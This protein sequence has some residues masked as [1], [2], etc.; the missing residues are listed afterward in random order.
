MSHSENVVPIVVFTML[1]APL[2]FTLTRRF[3][4]R[5]PA[6][7]AAP[8]IPVFF[9]LTPQQQQQTAGFSLSPGNLSTHPPKSPEKPQAQPKRDLVAELY[10]QVGQSEIEKLVDDFYVGVAKD[11]IIGPLYEKA[12]KERGEPDLGGAQQRLA[13]YLVGRFGGP[14]VYVEKHGHP[15]LKARHFSFP[16]TQEGREHW[17]TIMEGAVKSRKFPA[18]VEA[19]MMEFF[20]GL[21]VHMINTPN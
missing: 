16:V 3:L 7:A 9:P 4:F 14:P 6:L 10:A 20:S 18:P 5:A 13:E 8:V 2:V 21:S 17:M 19:T 11:P 15:R 12:I 1:A